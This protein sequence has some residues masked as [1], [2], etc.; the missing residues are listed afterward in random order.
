MSIYNN[1]VSKHKYD[2]EIKNKVFRS[3]FYYN[4]VIDNATSID[5][6]ENNSDETLSNPYTWYNYNN[7]N[8]KF[9]ISEIDADYLPTG[10]TIARSSRL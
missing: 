10:I 5:L 2:D 1:L 6:N 4:V 9:V 7:I 8:N 3:K